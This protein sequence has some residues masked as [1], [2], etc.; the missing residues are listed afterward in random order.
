MLIF[1]KKLLNRTFRTLFQQ[2]LLGSD[3]DFSGVNIFAL[4]KP[5]LGSDPPGFLRTAWTL[6]EEHGSARMLISGL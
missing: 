3:S 6:A 1:L 4:L 5:I 2:L